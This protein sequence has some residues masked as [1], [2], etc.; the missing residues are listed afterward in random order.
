MRL[1]AAHGTGSLTQD[2]EDR[3]H[4][5]YGEA[6]YRRLARIKAE[7]DLDNVFHLNANIRPS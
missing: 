7:Y 1:R 2:R 3:V 6:K 5:S 4:A